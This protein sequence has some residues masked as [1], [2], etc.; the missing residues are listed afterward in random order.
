MSRGG[1]S[2]G[3]NNKSQVLFG[4]NGLNTSDINMVENGKQSFI[5]GHPLSNGNNNVDSQ[6]S[7]AGSFL[8]NHGNLAFFS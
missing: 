4:I 7:S 1:G 6:G 2:D 3:S 8:G 5:Q